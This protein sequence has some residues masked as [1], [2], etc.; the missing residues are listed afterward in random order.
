MNAYEII[1]TISYV[2]DEN[3][4]LLG[5]SNFTGS[6]TVLVRYLGSKI[7]GEVWFYLY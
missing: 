4:D 6:S 1:I 3:P 2:V 7:N 5:A